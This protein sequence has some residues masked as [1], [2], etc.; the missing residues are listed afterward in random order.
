MKV[1]KQSITGLSSHNAMKPLYS[2]QSCDPKKCSLD[3][4]VHPKVV[5]YFHVHMCMKYSVGYINC[6]AAAV[7]MDTLSELGV[8]IPRARHAKSLSQSCQ[9][10]MRS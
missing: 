8:K 7:K 5:R 2:E 6:L 4:G 3:R 1:Y 10:V 9:V